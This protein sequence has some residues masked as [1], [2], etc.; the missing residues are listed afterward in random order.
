M[1]MMDGQKT[2]HQDRLSLMKIPGVAQVRVT[3]E[4]LD[5]ADLCGARPRVAKNIEPIPDINDVHESVLDNRVAPHYDLVRPAA[6]RRILQ[7]HGMQWRGR[8]PAVL[9]RM[10]RV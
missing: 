4:K 6:E 8:E 3:L 1:I 5:T 2:V 10:R 9:G 7:S